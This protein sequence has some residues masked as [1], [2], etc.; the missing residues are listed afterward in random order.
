[1][2]GGCGILI[3]SGLEIPVPRRLFLAWIYGSHVLSAN[4]KMHLL[5]FLLIEEVFLT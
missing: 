1:M 3:V 4:R 2:L 5:T